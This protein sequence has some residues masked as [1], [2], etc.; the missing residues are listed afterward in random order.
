MRSSRLRS[1]ALIATSTCFT[2]FAAC[3]DDSTNPSPSLPGVDGGLSGFDAPVGDT[4]TSA[5]VSA[6]DAG[7]DSN[8]VDGA[9]PDARVD[10]ADA[11][12][13]SDGAVFGNALAFDGI[14]DVVTMYGDPSET[15]F[16][17]ELWFKMTQIGDAG[18]PLQ[19]NM[20]S[21]W[22][23]NSGGADRFLFVDAGK[24]CF[25]VYNPG[26]GNPKLCSTNT[27]NDGA[28]HHVAGTLGNTNGI[29]VYVDGQEVAADA[30]T[31]VSTFTTGNAFRLGYGHYAFASGLIHMQ[32]QIDEVRVWSVERTAAEIAANYNKFV[33]ASTAGL[34]G[35]W[36]L[37]EPGTSAIAKD[38]VLASDGG[39]GNT[40]TLYNFVLDGGA[41]SPWV[42]PGAL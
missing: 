21:V 3:T 8:L 30:A 2:A 6:N 38:E 40:A 24:A 39:P 12:D 28:W 20:F 17:V 42:Y 14:D 5:D 34:Q 36:K 22:Q 10:A 35:Y 11:S 41:P 18:Y 15:A 25:Y 13:A 33:A 7:T 37:D 1:L 16:S 26:R 19:G 29:R 32:G 4:N 27:Y 9:V 23:T 31:K